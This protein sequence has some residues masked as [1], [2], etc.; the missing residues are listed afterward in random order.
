VGTDPFYLGAHHLAIGTIGCVVLLDGAGYDVAAQL[1]QAG[2]LLRSL[3]RR[4]FGDDTAFQARVSPIAQA[5]APNAGRFLIFH[6]ASRADSGA[7]SERLGA[8][9][10]G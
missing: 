1:R 10:R 2:P 3:Y 9:L 4:A 7:Q 5:A 6:I 8:I